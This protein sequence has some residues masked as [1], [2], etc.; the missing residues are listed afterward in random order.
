MDLLETFEEAVWDAPFAAAAQERALQ[1]LE[2]GRVLHFKHLAFRLEPH[3]LRFLSSAWS[4]Q[5]A[6]NISYDPNTGKLGGASVEGSGGQ[7]LPAMM[8]RY[9]ASTRELLRR[10]LP[11][12]GSALR[13]ARTSFRP[14][15]IEGRP[16]PSVRKDD[17]LLHPD[18]FPSRPMRGA[19]ILRVFTNINPSGKPRVWH[20]GEPFETFASRFLPRVPYPLPGRAWIEAKLGV[21]KGQRTLYDHIMLNLHDQGKYD[22]NYQRGAR[23]QEIAFASGSTWAVFT[24]QVLHAATAG[25]FALEQTFELPVSALIKPDLAPLRVLERLTGRALAA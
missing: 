22:T 11:Q 10:L 21:T 17:R 13:Q 18:A 25:Q 2:Q 5:K 16:V 4:D 3:E 23:R 19:R 9:A 12:Y 14:H 1:T 8:R 6:K 7:E 24:D 15:E 20:L